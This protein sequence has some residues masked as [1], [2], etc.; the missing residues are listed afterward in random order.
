MANTPAT[1]IGGGDTAEQL[2]LQFGT[3]V[4]HI[5][6]IVVGATTDGTQLGVALFPALK[7]AC[8]FLQQVTDGLYPDI[9]NADGTGDVLTARRFPVT[10]EDVRRIQEGDEASLRKLRAEDRRLRILLGDMSR[11]PITE[12]EKERVAAG[13]EYFLRILREDEDFW[14]NRVEKDAV[15]EDLGYTKPDLLPVVEEDC[16][17]PTAKEKKTKD[18]PFEDPTDSYGGTVVEEKEPVE[19]KHGKRS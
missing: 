17:K 11:F 6:A 18:L 7:A 14:K 4:R 2:S 15:C 19:K 8:L 10:D 13:D 5:E 1:S 12:E 16:D 3:A 9:V